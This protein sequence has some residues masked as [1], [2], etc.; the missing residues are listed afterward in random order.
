MWAISDQSQTVN[1]QR[2]SLIYTVPV[3]GGPPKRVTEQGPSYF[4]GWSPDGKTL[5]YC[6]QRERQLRRLHH[7]PWAAGREAA[8]HRA[9]QGRRPGVFTGRAVHLLQLRSQRDDADLAH[10]D[11]TARSRNRSPTTSSENW[12]PHI[13]PNGQVDGVP[14]L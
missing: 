4:H 9:G 11:R 10:E 12:F 2:P 1:G 6:G 13:A 5:T 3:G 7:R 8:D 14:D